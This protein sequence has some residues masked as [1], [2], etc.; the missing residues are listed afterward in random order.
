MLP[1]VMPSSGV[2]GETD[3]EFFGGPIKIAG[4]A[5]DQQAATFGQACFEVG[6]AKN[7][8]GTG[9]FMLMNTGE[10]AVH[11]KAGLVTTVAYRLGD[12]RPRFALEG[13]IAVAGALVQW[14]RDNLRLIERSADIEALARGVDDNGGVYF[15]PAFSGLYA[16]HWKADARGVIAGLTA[17][18]NRGHLARAVLEAT[19]YQTRDV[20]AAMERDCGSRL[21][22]LRVDGGMVAN[23]L[24]MQ[25]QA[26]ILDTSVARPRITE[27]TALGAA[28]AAGL[29]CGYWKDCEELKGSVEIE[30]RWMPSMSA[31]RR[32]ELCRS[33]EKAV[34]RS[35]AW[36]D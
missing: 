22:E 20:L 6:M 29:A 32:G 19:A 5:G 9:C 23:E 13:S 11:S 30:R 14:L 7:T 27:T 25:F 36:I 34:S 12:Q 16:P 18:A 17:Y 1:K 35:F 10:Q 33:W 2:F 15:V 28:Y 21:R 26:D 4:D 3:P 31:E 8:Y 24:L